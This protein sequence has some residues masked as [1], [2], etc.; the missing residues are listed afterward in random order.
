MPADFSMWVSQYSPAGYLKAVDTVQAS[1]TEP[2][3]D[4]E[5]LCSTIM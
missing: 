5:R 4:N 3:Q 1:G 2:D